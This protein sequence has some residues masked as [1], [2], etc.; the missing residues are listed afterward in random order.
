MLFFS[1]TYVHFVYQIM[2]LLS[3]CVLCS[4][5]QFSICNVFCSFAACFSHCSL[6]ICT[7]QTG[8]ILD[9][10]VIPLFLF[11]FSCFWVVFEIS[12]L[13][14]HLKE[15]WVFWTEWI[16]WRQS[17]L[18]RLLLA[19][20]PVC[21]PFACGIWWCFAWATKLT[22]VWIH[23][24][25]VACCAVCLTAFPCVLLSYVFCRTSK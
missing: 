18:S 15:W 6:Y 19:C 20:L 9:K 8:R 16:E 1:N 2:W 14:T 12:L 23:V 5:T 24:I 21:Q 25:I 13:I 7:P 17:V 4:L 11:E 22:T 3:A 10:Y